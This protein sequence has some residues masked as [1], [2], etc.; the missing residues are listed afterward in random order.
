MGQ[1]MV[2]E[3]IK[4]KDGDRD[5]SDDVKKQVMEMSV[6][7]VLHNLVLTVGAFLW[8]RE[9]P[10]FLGI[11]VGTAAAVGLLCSMAYST[12]LCIESGD[13]GY[14]QN[15][16]R[17]HAIFRSVT[18]FGGIILLWRFI[19]INPLAAAL[20][21]LGLKTGAYLYPLIHRTLNHKTGK[22]V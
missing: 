17:M 21:T 16:M 20:G 1:A 13:E 8:F 11:L 12:E 14:A 9:L 18:V 4:G 6:G 3:E 5:M 15:K 2:P 7:I 10:V 22:Q 19:D